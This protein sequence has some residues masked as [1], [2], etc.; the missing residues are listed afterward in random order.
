[1]NMNIAR[2]IAAAVVEAY[3]RERMSYA[4]LEVIVERAAETEI[5]SIGVP[6]SEVRLPLGCRFEM[7]E[8][9]R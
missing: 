6:A 3:D 1:M 9:Q 5:R 2:R 7:T 8:D 4:D